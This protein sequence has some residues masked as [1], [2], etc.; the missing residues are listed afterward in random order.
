MMTVFVFKGI[1][2]LNIDI[3]APRGSTTTVLGLFT[4]WAIGVHALNKMPLKILY[5][6][7]S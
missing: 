4:A 3:L 5:I 2:S 6:S 7:Y 1:A